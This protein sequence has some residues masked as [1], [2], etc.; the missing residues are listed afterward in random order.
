MC[1]IASPVCAVCGFDGH[2]LFR[3]CKYYF[4]TAA[5]E[6]LRGIYSMP[7]HIEDIPD[8]D[9]FTEPTY[10]PGYRFRCDTL[11]KTWDSTKLN[12]HGY[13]CEH[14]IYE[15]AM[16]LQS[17]D[18]QDFNA[19]LVKIRS[20]RK[21]RE[22]SKKAQLEYQHSPLKGKAAVSEPVD[23]EANFWK[24]NDHLREVMIDRGIEDY[25]QVLAYYLYFSHA[26]DRADLFHGARALD[27]EVSW[28]TV[29]EP[30]C[31]IC[32][33]EHKKGVEVE[34]NAAAWR[35]LKRTYMDRD[36]EISCQVEFST[37]TNPC[38]DC[39]ERE[40][41]LIEEMQAKAKLVYDFE[42]FPR[43]L[44]WIMARPQESYLVDNTA[45]PWK[46][47]Y[48]ARGTP[49]SRLLLKQEGHKH[50]VEMVKNVANMK[51]K[52]TTGCY[53]DDRKQVIPE[54]EK[55]AEA[56]TT[57]A[58]E[59]KG[60]KTGEKAGEKMPEKV[61]E[62]R[63][64]EGG[65]KGEKLAKKQVPREGDGKAATLKRARSDSETVSAGCSSSTLSGGV[66]SS[67]AARLLRRRPR[68]RRRDVESTRRDKLAER[69]TGICDSDGELGSYWEGLAAVP[70]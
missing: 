2:F 61:G 60:E 7:A 57:E 69:W 48:R 13:I 24:V 40:Q 17:A 11:D 70:D 41:L 65:E 23:T 68:G 56:E 62:E 31:P 21:E 39:Q 43:L 66:V 46:E 30:T 18:D 47:G 58:G 45:G 15:S 55:T 50:E 26:G 53:W 35:S 6:I 67:P 9:N 14:C 42:W 37:T 44:G 32:K 3:P 28:L 27:A 10:R 19:K 49:E 8:V 1:V 22:E 51:W 5:T 59:K 34:P 63:S 52:K 38:A 16:L 64:E 4:A 25:D 12:E 29:Y 36:Q 54:P 33:V 20:R